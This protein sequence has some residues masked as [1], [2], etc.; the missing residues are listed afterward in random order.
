MSSDTTSD[1]ED[2]DAYV[3]TSHEVEKRFPLHDCVEFDDID[4]LKV[5]SCP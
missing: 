3:E 4:A 1:D 2:Y 5:S